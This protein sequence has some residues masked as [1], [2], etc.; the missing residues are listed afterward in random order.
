MKPFGV[1]TLLL[2]AA[3]LPGSAAL[4]SDL[5]SAVVCD[6]FYSEKLRESENTS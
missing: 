2:F 3:F 4:L 5:S 6:D 1:L